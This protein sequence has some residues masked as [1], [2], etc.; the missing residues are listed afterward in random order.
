M[1]SVSI[2]KKFI[3]SGKISGE[4]SACQ[5]VGKQ[6]IVSEAPPSSQSPKQI[7]ENQHAKHE[8][9]QHEQKALEAGESKEIVG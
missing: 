8:H 9:A 3:W 5:F 1:H 7:A 2:Q 6:V 4:E